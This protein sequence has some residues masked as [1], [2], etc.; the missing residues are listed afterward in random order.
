MQTIEPG[1]SWAQVRPEWVALAVSMD[2]QHDRPNIITLGW[3]MHTSDHPSMAAIA[4]G[5]GGYSRELI[6]RERE[7]VL[8]YP[9]ARMGAA[10]LYCGTHSGRDVDK[11]ANTNLVPV[12]AKIVKP[13]L[14]QGAVVNMECKVVGTLET[15]DHTLFVGEIVA[16]HGDPE[17]RE[18][19]L[20][21]GARGS[22]GERLLTGLSGYFEHM[23]QH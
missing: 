5:H 16:A 1:A 20:N 10:A 7:F 11:F 8:A 14:I 4:I 22:S 19:L 13:P 21:F 17:E 3:T 2:A 6:M 9:N 12:P 23:R 15:G 18:I